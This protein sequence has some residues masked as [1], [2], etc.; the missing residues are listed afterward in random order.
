MKIGGA[1]KM[2]SIRIENASV[3]I[4]KGTIKITPQQSMDKQD[5]SV[6]L[7]LV[8]NKVSL[9][10]LEVGDICMIGDEEFIILDKDYDTR[11]NC[12]K[13]G[14][15]VIHKSLLPSEE[16]GESSDWKQS[17]IRN[18]LNGSY[19]GKIEKEVSE[20]CIL[21]FHRDLTSID[22]LDDYGSCIDRLS[23]LSVAEYA[24]YHKILGLMSDYSD[25]WWTIT[26]RST[27]SNNAARSVC[28]V[29]SSGI[30]NWGGCDYRNGVRPFMVLES[31]TLVSVKKNEK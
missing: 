19:L 25:W 12:N 17:Y 26:P 6:I 16:F 28:R 21:P 18:K 29:D 15:A 3:V 8:S 9:D 13:H 5:L 11:L 23:L 30:L 20:D 24:K 10:S 22:G 1:D 4:D 31:S 14:I 27:P 7:D 2:E